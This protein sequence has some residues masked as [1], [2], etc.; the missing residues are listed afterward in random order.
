MISNV[1]SVTATWT[2]G[3]AVD[4]W[5]CGVI[6]YAMLAGYLPFDDDPANPDGDN[7]NLLYKYIMATPL[8]FPDYITA[9]P[10][11][12]LSKMLVPDPLRRANDDDVMSHSWLLPYRDLF[13]FSV[14]DL[15][16]AAMEQQSKKRQAYR[17]QMAMQQQE[18][19]EQQQQQSMVRSQSTRNDGGAGGGAAS[20]PSTKAQRHQSAVVSGSATSPNI[21]AASARSRPVTGMPVP[22]VPAAASPARS[23]IS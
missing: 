17:Q 15:E 4:V 3:P 1:K 9:E 19:Q 22:V 8:S 21:A 11:D 13:K 23:Y 12:L 2:L 18:Q 7:I 5:S 20:S 10:R 14:D 6:L 16:K